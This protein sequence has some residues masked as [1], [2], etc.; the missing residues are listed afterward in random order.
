MNPVPF[1]GAK[2]SC[3]IPKRRLSNRGDALEAKEV[4]LSGVVEDYRTR[5]VLPCSQ[6]ADQLQAQ[7]RRLKDKFENAMGVNAAQGRKTTWKTLTSFINIILP[8][9]LP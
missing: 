3:P 4:G 8:E 1:W 2:C 9:L 5:F 6:N 7:A